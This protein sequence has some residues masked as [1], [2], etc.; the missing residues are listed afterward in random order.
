MDTALTRLSCLELKATDHCR[1]TRASC[2]LLRVRD[3]TTPRVLKE[4]SEPAEEH[5]SD[6]SRVATT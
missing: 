4:R 6:I 1:S 2:V 5:A 3:N